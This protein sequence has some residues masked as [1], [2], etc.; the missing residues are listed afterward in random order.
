MGNLMNSFKEIYGV[1]PVLQT[2]FNSQD[3]IDKPMLANEVQWVLEQGADGVTTGMVTEI[4]RLSPAERMDLHEIVSEISNNNGALTVL[5][6]GS[7][8]LKQSILYTKHAEACNAD[9]VMV[10]PPLTTPLSDED[11]YRYYGSI[12]DATDIP[13]IVQD[14]SGYIGRPLSLELQVKL[15]DNYGS[16]VYFK[17]EAIPI[18]PRLT[19]FME[20]TSGRAKV[21]EGSGGGALIDTFQRGLVGTMP[22]AD[23]TWAIVA[24]WEA[25]NEGDWE[26]VDRI[27]G[28][29]ANLISLEHSLDA[30]LAIEKYLLVKQGIFESSRVREPVGYSMDE[31]TR[32]NVDRLFSVLK[33]RVLDPKESLNFISTIGHG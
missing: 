15:L 20:A 5:S 19:I 10:N 2:P 22:G 30:Y 18:G 32:M 27:G 17:P 11:L 31:Q 7:E 13:M 3:E 23:L 1:L 14:A 33:S 12:L 21:F 16:R 26:Q 4:L 25:L 29:L 24:L 28:P 8:S 6:T 9:A